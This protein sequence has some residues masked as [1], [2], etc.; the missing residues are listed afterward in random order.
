MSL[1]TFFSLLV[2]SF[3]TSIT[4]GPNNIMLLSSGVLYGLRRTIPHILGIG[5][6]FGFLLAGVG[7]GLSV[8]ISSYPILFLS[9]KISGG[10]Y[11]LY[12]AWRIA[13]SG[14]L[15]DNDSTSRPM[16]FYEAA[17]FQWVNAKAWVMAI[18]AMSAYTSE[19]SY[20]MGV[21]IVIF[22]F[23]LVNM[24]C[25]GC[26]A[27]FGVVLRRFLQDPIKLR[28]FNVLM[29]LALVASLWPIVRTDI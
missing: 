5:F 14:G 19:G 1:P 7:L 18:V 2:F 17:L 22:S 3:V 12:L 24:P 10:L 27:V 20:M 29:A 6:G 21:F 11:M 26:W 23:C 25:V 13:I 8:I 4:P 28:I 9:I 16:Y 15:S